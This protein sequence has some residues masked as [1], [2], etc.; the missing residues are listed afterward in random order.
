MEV[1]EHTL[2]TALLGAAVDAAAA[3]VFVADSAMTNVAVNRTACEELGYTREE[4]LRLRVSDVARES[5][6]TGD[7]FELVGRGDRIGTAELTRRDGT[8]C[9]FT[10]RASQVAVGGRS[11]YV[12]V[13]F[14]VR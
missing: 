9:R 13:G 5:S 1:G 3:L 11:L 14:V 12:A 10:Y 4:L 2:Q 7:Y 6:A 8:T